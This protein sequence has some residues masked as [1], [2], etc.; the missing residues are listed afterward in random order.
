MR[1]RIRLTLDQVRWFDEVY[2]YIKRYK[3]KGPSLVA[4]FSDVHD[5]NLLVSEVR[6]LVRKRLLRWFPLTGACD[7]DSD[8]MGFGS[9]CTVDMTPRAIELLTPRKAA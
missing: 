8:V 4:A 7:K 2:Q 5:G 6:P 9:N 3:C 1:R